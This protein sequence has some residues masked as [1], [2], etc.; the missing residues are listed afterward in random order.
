MSAVIDTDHLAEAMREQRLDALVAAS[1]E[2]VQ[3]SAGVTLVTQRLIP[4]RLAMVVWRP[5]G[6]ATALVEALEEEVTR[7]R[8]TIADVG[9]YDEHADGPVP[10]LAGLLREWGVDGGR[11]GIEARF[12]VHD[13]TARMAAALPRATLVPADQIFDALR[14]RKSKVE[15]EHLEGTARLLEDVIAMA[16][17]VARPGMTERSLGVQMLTDLTKRSEGRLSGLGATVASGPNAH[18]THHGMADRRLEDGDLIRL[19]CRGVYEGYHGIVMRTGVIGRPPPALQ[20]IHRDLHE[21]HVAVI[22]ALQ[23]GTVAQ[24][25]YREAQRQYAA[26][27]YTLPLPHVGHSV[28]LALQERPKFHA[29]ATEALVSDMVCVVVNVIASEHGR[30]YLE[31]MVAIDESGPRLLSSGGAGEL[32]TVGRPPNPE[33]E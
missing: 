29:G 25:I 6:S 18:V 3:Y 16:A 33:K 26:R 22:Q 31:D 2:N 20:R 21:I 28:G 19:G 13:V 7:R 1:P 17:T 11:I 12:L 9:T 8:G 32:L 5:S 15:Q 23:P 24:T 14:V 30:F 27:G 4:E 10:A